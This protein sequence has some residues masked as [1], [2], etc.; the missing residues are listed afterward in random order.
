MLLPSGMTNSKAVSIRL[1][2][3]E[4]ASD[5]RSIRLAALANAP[6]AFGSTYEEESARPMSTFVN[7]TRTSS[8]FG[9]YMDSTIVGIARFVHH[10]GLKER[11]KGSLRGMYVAPSARSN[12]VGRAL[13][14]AVLNH[15][16]SVVEQ[17]MLS[18]VTT[19]L[20]AIA[21]YKAFG[22]E[23]YG[24][25]PRALKGDHGYADEMFMVRYSARS[26]QS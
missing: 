21:L 17:V 6:E 22:F 15:A 18:V 24:I 13:I 14:T 19:N 12:G 9:A 16:D 7:Q 5:Y 11:H 20:A 8:I 10:P 25:E 4:D 26:N 1:L 23:S 2:L 3:P